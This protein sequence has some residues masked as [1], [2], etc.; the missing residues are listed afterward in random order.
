MILIF[1]ICSFIAFISCLYVGIRFLKGYKKGGVQQLRNF[2]LGFLFISVGYLF[3]AFPDWILFNPTLI[4]SCF[5]M[6]D[7]FFLLASVFLLTAALSFL[8]LTLRFRNI[9]FFGGLLTLAT[10][11][12]LNFIYFQ[13]AI[14]LALEGTYYWKNGVFWLHSLL[15]VPSASGAGI[16]GVLFLL[17]AKKVKNQK[18]LLRSLCFGIASFLIFVA[19]IL[20]WYFKFFNPSSEVAAVSGITVVISLVIGLI[21]S[22]FYQSSDDN[23]VKKID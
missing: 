9:I 13:P 14:S 19:G 4:Q 6:V 3:L 16:I 23:L 22:A 18:L 11:V 15:W 12:L 1:N 20:F 21:G 17:E 8:K 7:V 2:A 10:Y 5:I